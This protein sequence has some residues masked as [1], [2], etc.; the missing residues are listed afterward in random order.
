MSSISIREE[1]EEKKRQK[2]SCRR[3]RNKSVGKGVRATE[4]EKWRRRR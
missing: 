1:V 4:V 2:E 3:K